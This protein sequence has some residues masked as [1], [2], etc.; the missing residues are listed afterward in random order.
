MGRRIAALLLLVVGCSPPAPPPA[1]LP[2]PAP[3]DLG[4]CTAGFPVPLTADICPLQFTREGLACVD[5][6]GAS[7]CFDAEHG[8]YCTSGGCSDPRC[9]TAAQ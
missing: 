9:A 7:G 8:V 2:R 6:V 5:C 3:A 1:P 4:T